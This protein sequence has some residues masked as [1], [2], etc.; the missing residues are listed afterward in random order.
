[1]DTQGFDLQVFRGAS[2]CL[3][4][5]FG[6]QSELSV[7]PIYESMPHY[8]EA[9]E[10]YESVGFTLHSLHPVA[11]EYNGAVIEYNCLLSK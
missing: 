5:I 11:T 9:L 10:E 1:M 8:I 3:D 2:G 6:I 7:R 4:M